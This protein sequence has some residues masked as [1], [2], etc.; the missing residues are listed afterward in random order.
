MSIFDNGGME[1]AI[2]SKLAE[3]LGI[4]DIPR[5]MLLTDV[6]AYIMG[7]LIERVEKLEK[8]V[9]ELKEKL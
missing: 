5:H 8:E 2:Y 3:A 1:C 9:K 6:P 7:F 4:K